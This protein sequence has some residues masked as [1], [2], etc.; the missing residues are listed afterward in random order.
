M[1]SHD[2][3][4]AVRRLSGQRRVGHGGTLDPAAA[5][6]LPVALGQATRLLEY[7]AGTDKAYRV[8][9]TFG[10]RTDTLDAVG[11]VLEE[12]PGWELTAGR[13]ASLLVPFR[14]EILQVPPAYAAVRVGGERAHRLARRGV[15]VQLPPRRVRIG[16]LELLDF[17]PGRFPRAMLDL[18][19]SKG[20]YVRSLARDLG[21]AARTGAYVSFL[22][23]L[24][25]GPF[26][27][28]EACTLEELGR[29][30]VAAHLSE[31]RS[32]LGGVPAVT[33]TAAEAALIRN[34]VAPGP[35]PGRYPDG[36]VQLLDAEGML[37]AMGEA[38]QG[39]CRLRKVLGPWNS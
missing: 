25:V 24:R 14:G 31:V 21:E 13:V 30:G 37:L 18:V 29:D 33:V 1:T 27:V 23:R 6:V 34:G 3:V 17:T 26:P 4:A 39:I 16:R 36:P 8:E 28:E 7:L 11:R 35:A 12:R 22:L 10:R 2:V 9:V 19:C 5:G 20:T 15:A 38:R 32:M